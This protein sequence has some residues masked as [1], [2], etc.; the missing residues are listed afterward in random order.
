MITND[1]YGL[2]VE[3]WRESVN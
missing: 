2:K 1:G 3:R